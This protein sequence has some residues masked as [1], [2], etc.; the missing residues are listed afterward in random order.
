[1]RVEIDLQRATGVADLPEEDDFRRWAE[2]VLKGR[3]KRTELTIRVVDEIESRNL[4]RTYRG[5][6]KATN[7]LSFPFDAPAVAGSDLLGDLVICAPLVQREAELQGKHA[8][9]HWAHLV[10]H[11]LLHLLGLDH[12]T[13]QEAAEME[14]VE[15]TIL[16][17]LG[18]SDPYSDDQRL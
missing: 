11:G 1:V 16:S 3:R 18:F 8:S 15:V 7:V 6:D 5:Q 2:M 13:D 10:V 12:R 17:R 14:S 4:N 9:A